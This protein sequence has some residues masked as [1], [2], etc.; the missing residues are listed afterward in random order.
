MKLSFF[1]SG[2]T[3]TSKRSKL[4]H[5]TV[6]GGV[7]DSKSKDR[8]GNTNATS[9]KPATRSDFIV[10]RR[11]V[12]PQISTTLKT[13]RE[14]HDAHA[15]RALPRV[16]DLPTPS[17]FT[18]TAG[19]EA[20]PPQPS[21]APASS[22]ICYEDNPLRG[23]L[24]FSDEAT[25][26]CSNYFYGQLPDGGGLGELAS[27]Y[28]P[29]QISSACTCFEHKV[30]TGWSATTRE[31]SVQ[32]LV[33]S[34]LPQSTK[35]SDKTATEDATF[36][37]PSEHLGPM[38][39]EVPFTAEGVGPT[40]IL[41]YSISSIPSETVTLTSAT[42]LA[43]S[44][45]PTATSAAGAA[46]VFGDAS[47]WRGGGD[48]MAPGVVAVIVN[49]GAMEAPSAT[50]D[51]D[52]TAM[53]LAG[54]KMESAVARKRLRSLPAQGASTLTETT[55]HSKGLGIMNTTTESNPGSAIGPI[56]QQTFHSRT[57]EQSPKSAPV[58]MK[59][60]SFET[61]DSALGDSLSEADVPQH[62]P[63]ATPSPSALRQ[64]FNSDWQRN[65]TAIGP[66]QN[67]P[68]PLSKA[69]KRRGRPPGS[70]NR[71]R[72]S[73]PDPQTGWNRYQLLP[74]PS[75][76]KD[77]KK[78]AT[79]EQKVRSTKISAAMRASWARRRNDGSIKSRHGPST[80]SSVSKKRSVKNP[81]NQDQTSYVEPDNQ[82]TQR[83]LFKGQ[84]AIRSGS[85]HKL[86]GSALK[87]HSAIEGR[88]D[89][90]ISRNAELVPLPD[91]SGGPE[92]D[93]PPLICKGDSGLITVFRTCVYP[94]A[95]A[96]VNRY[97]DTVLSTESLNDICKQVAKDTINEKFVDFLQQTE[98]KL[99][100]PQRKLV[101]KYV[102]AGFAAAA[103][104]RIKEFQKQMLK[105]RSMRQEAEP[106]DL[107]TANE[108]DGHA[109]RPSTGQKE[110]ANHA[111]KEE[112]KLSRARRF[113]S[114]PLA[115]G[116]S[117]RSWP[118][119]SATGVSN[120]GKAS[121][122]LEHV[123]RSTIPGLL[124]KVNESLAKDIHYD[125][126]LTLYRHHGP[127]PLPSWQ[128]SYP[129][130]SQ[131]H[132]AFNPEL[133]LAMASATL[134]NPVV[135][136][137]YKSL[138]RGHVDFNRE[139]C[140]F[141][142]HTLDRLNQLPAD[143][144]PE[145][146]SSLCQ[147]IKARVGPLPQEDLTTLVK[148]VFNGSE[149]SMTGRKRKSIRTFLDDLVN[150]TI[151]FHYQPKLAKPRHRIEPIYR[152]PKATI[153]S[154][155]RTRELGVEFGRGS[156]VSHA[157]TQSSNL[158][159]AIGAKIAE[160]IR[161]WKSWKGASSDVVVV[162]WSPDSL[163]YAAGAAAQSD[164][165]DLQ[166]N[167]PNNLLFGQLKS[168]TISEL[169]DHC[170]ERP[171]PET[172]QSGPN[173]SQAVYDACDPLVYKTVTSVQFSPS[174]SL[175]Y[176]AS[177]DSTAKI[178]D[179][180]GVGLPNC[181]STLPHNAGVTSLEV[182][183]YYTQVF[184]TAAKSIDDSIRVYRP[185]GESQAEYQ[186]TS[187]S[188]ERALKHPSQQM[189]PEC[190][191]WGLAPGSQH[192][193]LGG[194]HQWGDQDFSAA[195]QGELCLWDMHAETSI[196]VRPHTSAIL[197]AAWHPR[198]SIFITGSAPGS[199]TLSYPK[200]TQS[201]VR[202]YDPRRTASFT[203]EFE[204]PAL[205]MQDI[206]FHPFSDYVTAGCTDGTTYVWDCRNPD[207]VL[208]RL[209]HGDPLQ[210]LASNEEGIPQIK[211]RER[212]D[213]GVMLSIWSQD[214]SLFYTGSSDGIVKAWDI[215]RAPEDVWVK[216][217][218]QLPAGI[219]SGALSPDNMNML[220]G[221]AVG[222]VHV[223]SAAPLG[224]LSGSDDGIG[225]HPGSINFVAATYHKTDSL[226]E[227]GTEG[228]D[229]ANQLLRSGQLVIHPS[230]GAGK[231]LNY[232]RSNC[233]AYARWM[234]NKTGLWELQPEIDKKQA[235]DVDGVE[236]PEQS[237]KIRNVIMARKEQLTAEQK[238]V[239]PL[240]ICFGPPTPFVANRRPGGKSAAKPPTLSNRTRVSA[241][242]QSS[243]PD[244]LE[245]VSPAPAL[246]S[247]RTSKTQ[248]ATSK[249]SPHVK[250]STDFI[251]LETYVSP[252]CVSS[253][254]RK[255][256]GDS[257]PSKSSMK[258]IKTD[259][260]SSIGHR[261]S[262]IL[263]GKTEVVDLTGDDAE[264]ADV[265][266]MKAANS[267]ILPDRKPRP[268][269][270][271]MTKMEEKEDE[272]EENQLSWDEWVEEDHWWPE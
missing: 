245:A 132:S 64:T 15:Q 113:E 139:E 232:E 222:G 96:S 247:I 257:S 271:N 218:A 159:D 81:T 42:A 39:S 157:R 255:R 177:H 30:A 126:D 16:D 155:L 194:F 54:D 1:S 144:Y 8:P 106:N 180:S 5:R 169:P 156:P 43:S 145:D 172:I 207:N 82:E 236:Q 249:T 80:E 131:T 224:C 160:D 127:Q 205:D 256:D 186:F 141:I 138:K 166:Y 212:V 250:P 151:P 19:P 46:A 67:T 164:D 210:E 143:D 38:T 12:P 168:N 35:D 192:L 174:G 246:S 112:N 101:R 262:P 70:K 146:T 204:C 235:F 102:K 165:M 20:R 231:G 94:T 140:I 61:V 200:V 111:I 123:S 26:F 253:R 14:S 47:L 219:Q 270:I 66:Q 117:V 206:T 226:A 216:D 189:F 272:L 182:S 170:I 233:A 248:P 69:G 203:A 130:T 86:P 260:S 110:S 103:N 213:S 85:G 89:H 136:R 22:F 41:G 240:V 163:S 188:S 243:S 4:R 150:N 97:R 99:D 88:K 181:I 268:Y 209:R 259:R 116:P 230:F 25:T 225:Y 65:D 100:R 265:K 220:V 199:G 93:D 40:S 6:T 77:V 7:D 147:Q 179:V 56:P 55:T 211:H 133:E 176:T 76:S 92:V 223:L 242:Y 238:G 125:W 78:H 44:L 162:A 23:L 53:T 234:N 135:G 91:T 193:L 37:R 84:H 153:H 227:E 58:E 95:V 118:A 267:M 161:P 167:R 239:E 185:T 258:R 266:T 49:F 50:P 74:K 68:V 62:K 171:R 263:H 33:Q 63:S 134:S 24:R 45:S 158:Q 104:H 237:A 73:V 59:G 244:P 90:T 190:L 129:S 114:A 105:S 120:Q 9:A 152:E 29:P 184:A 124:T 21:L 195:R 269:A 98:Y 107:L 142:L 83:K 154:L 18:Q 34:Y 264:F 71:E 32:D 261:G 191:R 119:F 48:T 3:S 72:A 252:S 214:A 198:G 57:S 36:P 149:N 148:E 228:I 187:F 217:V 241:D 28:P 51:A 13:I 60:Q 108:L 202:L 11:E 137:P 122:R 178:W 175:L 197:A 208:H 52:T 115:L 201:V 173:S 183:T 2:E 251:D 128:S 31:P 215:L 75:V 229:Q 10:G 17:P 27:S 196:P 79:P 109:D 121:D 221:D 87:R 254:K